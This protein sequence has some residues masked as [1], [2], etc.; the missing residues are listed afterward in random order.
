[1]SG[2]SL[3]PRRATAVPAPCAASP[4]PRGEES[5]PIRPASVSAQPSSDPHHHHCASLSAAMAAILTCRDNVGCGGDGMCTPHLHP[6]GRPSSGCVG[7]ASPFRTVAGAALSHTLHGAVQGGG[8]RHRRRTGGR[9]SRPSRDVRVNAVVGATTVDIPGTAAQ[10]YRCCR[11]P[12]FRPPARQPKGRRRRRRHQRWQWWPA[13]APS[14]AQPR[15]RGVS[16][17]QAWLC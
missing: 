13:A 9:D 17:A 7:G 15:Q 12:I 16:P 4:P 14:R 3:P 8:G 10:R 1:M 2:Q 6:S 11:R 5:L